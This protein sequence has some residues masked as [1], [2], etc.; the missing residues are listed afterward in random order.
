MFQE[1]LKSTVLFAQNQQDSVVYLDRMQGA[2]VYPR[3]PAC[4]PSEHPTSDPNKSETE[5]KP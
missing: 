5:G 4:Q 3:A 2:A 1:D